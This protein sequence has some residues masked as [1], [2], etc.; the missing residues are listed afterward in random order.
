[1]GV[2]L[3]WSLRESERWR[4]FL[5]TLLVFAGISV[6]KEATCLSLSLFHTESL[7][8]V[9][10]LPFIIS[11]SSSASLSKEGSEMEPNDALN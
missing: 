6:A 3:D 1:M 11:F 8:S 9:P 5:A 7:T 2:G 4:E 10:S